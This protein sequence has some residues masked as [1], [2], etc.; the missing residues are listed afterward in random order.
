MKNFRLD[1]WHKK[2]TILSTTRT[3]NKIARI[4]AEEAIKKIAGVVKVDRNIFFGLNVNGKSICP[5]KYIAPMV[6]YFQDGSRIIVDPNVN[7]MRKYICDLTKAIYDVEI[8]KSLD[9]KK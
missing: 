4:A 3:A 1:F 8:V 2:L 6:A 9:D 7:K 5:G